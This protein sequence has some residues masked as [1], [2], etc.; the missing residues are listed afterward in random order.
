M[1]NSV[2]VIDDEKYICETLCTA[3]S[4]AGF[5]ADAA[6]S[7]ESG[8]EKFENGSYSAVILDVNLPRMNGYEAMRRIRMC[9]Y[10]TVILLITAH[11]S[12]ENAV[13]AIKTG[14][15]DYITKPFL[16]EDL[17][18]KLTQQL[19]LHAKHYRAEPEPE[20]DG[21]LIGASKFISDI[22]HVVQRV[23][24]LGVTVLIT[25]ESGT[26]KGVVAKYIHNAGNRRDKPF[27]YVNCAAIPANLMESELFGYEKG[28]F[29]GAYVTKQGKFE[30][31][32]DGT[33][34]LDEI[35][36]LST[37]LQAKLLG[38]LQDYCI[39]RVGGT[40]HI[41]IQ[42]RVIA[43]TNENLEEAI[44]NGKF[45]ED[46]Y[47]RLNV[48]KLE[49]PPL[50]FRKDDIELLA[51]NFL[52]KAEAEIGNGVTFTGTDGF[53]DALRQ[54]DWPGNVR[55]LENTLRRIA[56][57]SDHTQ[58]TAADLPP[59]IRNV[60]DSTQSR[61]SLSVKEQEL[62]TILTALELNHGHR[63]KT[64]QYLGISRRTLQ[65]RLKEFGLLNSF[66][67]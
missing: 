53:W 57:L 62:R 29:T 22:R 31:A 17:L 60:T 58:L 34:F 14:A 43:A 40:A 49:V 48:I 23:K 15:D 32:K 46:L 12:I 4:I 36:S 6:Y 41:P 64:A 9:S 61:L 20:G 42:A 33:I 16:C 13:L 26:G 19:Q 56:I 52:E 21:I 65:S 8:L 10:D 28:A 18:A 38:T 59:E 55:E 25:G 51:R 47:Y 35:G 66:E 7:G 11:G 27:V 24:N 45:R 3:L 54:Y 37:E 5:E 30:L 1:K 50:R 63:E 44:R 67:T 2:L 39:D